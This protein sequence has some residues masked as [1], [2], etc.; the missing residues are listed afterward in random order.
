[1]VLSLPSDYVCRIC[2]AELSNSYYHCMGCEELLAEDMNICLNCYEG[3]AYYKNISTRSTN[4]VEA[5]WV[6]DLN[7]TGTN[8]KLSNTRACRCRQGL[9]KKCGYC[10]SCSCRC[11]HHFQHNQRF[12]TLEQI[13]EDLD[14]IRSFVASRQSDSSDAGAFVVELC[15][16]VE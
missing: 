15:T 11:H 14:R 9:C 13:Q 3:A 6:S 8:D 2:H 16:T 4:S 5:N 12:F 10:K 7:H 1:M